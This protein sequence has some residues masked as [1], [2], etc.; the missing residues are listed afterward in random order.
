M[1]KKYFDGNM[2]GGRF[3]ALDS[4]GSIKFGEEGANCELK[5]LNSVKK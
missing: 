5:T 4:I 1:F 3:S 2:E